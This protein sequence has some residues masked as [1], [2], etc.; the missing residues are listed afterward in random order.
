MG[1]AA[2]S[3]GI[4]FKMLNTSKGRAVWSLRAQVDKKNYPKFIINK[5][6][7]CQ[8]ITILQD[9]VVDFTVNNLG[10]SAV[11]LR[12]GGV[13]KARSLVVCGGTFFN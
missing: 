2:D 4:Q 7:A 3:S 10:I 9:E 11:I 1:L 6:N 13:I 12:S 8:N 5:I